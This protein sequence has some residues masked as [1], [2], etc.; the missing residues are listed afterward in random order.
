[1]KR[2]HS[3]ILKSYFGPFILTFLIAMFVL[4]MQFLWKYIDEMVGKGLDTSVIVELLTYTSA[5]LV[6]MALPLAILISSIMTFG[7]F[8]EN[9]E[10]TAMKAAGMSLMN[11]MRPLI[12]MAVF[13]GVGAF[14][15]SNYVLPKA[16]LKTGAL[17]YD[18]RHKRPELNIKEGSFNNIEDY[19]IKIGKKNNRTQMMYNFMFYDH[20]KQN[21]N[22]NVTVA[23]SAQLYVT[24]DQKFLVI[25]LYHGYSFMD[26]EPQSN[27]K[28]PANYPM[29][30][31]KFDQQRLIRELNEGGMKRTDEGMFKR[32]YQMEN[33]SQLDFTIDSLKKDYVIQS[34]TLRDNII[35]SNI[36][37]NEQ[38]FSKTADSVK[39]MQIADRKLTADSIV[40]DYDKEIPNMSKAQK[41]QLINSAASFANASQTFIKQTSEDLDFRM[42]TINRHIIEWHRKFTLSL[43][44]IIFFFIGAPLGAIIRKGGLGWPIVISVLFFVFY[45]VVSLTGEKLTRENLPAIYGMWGSSYILIPLG[46]FLTYKATVDSAVMQTST[47]SDFFKRLFKK[48][49]K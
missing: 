42:L 15:F 4:L 38:H 9:Y 39:Y 19:V 13:I 49:E 47:Y 29:Q 35:S 18:I 17:L 30:R 23:D 22:K 33:L 2:L 31:N 45:Y 1:V 10:L 40:I 6:P 46:F 20:S 32:N 37:R 27:A 3:F 26:V 8:G 7:N 36:F 14:L 25:N 34:N 43:A 28:K 44:C 24:K 11:V 48:K 16:Q 12:F 5:S 21:G 41:L